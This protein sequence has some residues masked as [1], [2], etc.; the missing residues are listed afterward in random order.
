MVKRICLWSWFFL[1]GLLA[2]SQT[3]PQTKKPITR[4]LFIFDASYS[5][6]LNWEKQ[7]KIT[8]ARNILINL[9]DSLERV[10]N[11]ELALRVYGHQKPVPPKDCSDTKLEVPFEKGNASKIRQKLRFIEPMG[12]T[13][14]AYSLSLAS[15]DFGNTTD[16]RNIIILISDGVEA[17]D[18][19]PCA[20]AHELQSKGIALKPFII[21][22]GI[23]EDFNKSFDCIGRFYN[24]KKEEQLKNVLNIVVNQALNSTTAQINL[25]DINGK[26]NETDVNMSFYDY[27]SG[28]P[29]HNY[30][31]TIN[32]LGNPD[33]LVLDPL[34]TYRLVVNTIPPV[35][36]DSFKVK[37]GTHN[38]ISLKAPQGNLIVRGEG[39]KLKDLAFI[40]R[41]AGESTSLNYQI[42]NQTEK[43]LVGKYDIEIPVFP[44]IKVN[45]IEIKQS[46]TTSISIP[47]PGFVTFLMTSQGIGSIYLREPNK[48]LQWVCNLNVAL[49]NETIYLQ[50][51]SYMLVYRPLNAKQILY[52]VTRSFEVESGKSNLVQ[53]F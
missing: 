31:H 19:D 30:M 10:P 40:V 52:T 17:C 7:K 24:A 25:L 39:S 4:M 32:N 2:F 34:V 27:Y 33:T 26:P 20:V 1:A 22:I 12:T 13:P 42:I 21:G 28:K 45:N 47:Q 23:E 15:K 6:N 51:G 3:K 38:I 50:P 5:M 49:K 46:T 43:Y 8:V 41:K 18:G 16:Y 35:Q 11:V 53:L 44:K 36:K 29:K 14:L 9:I 37:E 48:P